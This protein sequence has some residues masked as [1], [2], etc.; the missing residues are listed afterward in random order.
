MR[1]RSV[2][3]RRTHYDWRNAGNVEFL[4][5]KIGQRLESFRGIRIDN[6]CYERC[7]LITLAVHSLYKRHR[8]VKWYGKI[9]FN[10]GGGALYIHNKMLL[11]YGYMHE[12]TLLKSELLCTR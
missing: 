9:V 5:P 12:R 8:S 1:V 4:S 3:L 7:S 2:D 10:V 6:Q 11:Y